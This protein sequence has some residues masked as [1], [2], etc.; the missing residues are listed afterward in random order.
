[1]TVLTMGPTD[2]GFIISE[3]N[4][5]RSRGVRTLKSGSVYE[6]GS[7]VVAEHKHRRRRRSGTPIG[8]VSSTT[9]GGCTKNFSPQ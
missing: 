7:V 2:E 6:P 9:P 8:H 5:F 3:A 1:M 4:G